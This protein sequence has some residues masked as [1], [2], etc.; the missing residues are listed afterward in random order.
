MWNIWVIRPDRWWLLF[1]KPDCLQLYWMLLI[2]QPSLKTQEWSKCGPWDF[3]SHP[4]AALIIWRFDLQR[5]QV[6][7]AAIHWIKTGADCPA[8]TVQNKDCSVLWGRSIAYQEEE[9][10]IEGLVHS[11]LNAN[12]LCYQFT[13]SFCESYLGLDPENSLRCTMLSVATPDF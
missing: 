6:V 1:C 7:C 2:K 13:V 12:R 10:L 3:T 5:F 9:R 8:P 11:W 4:P